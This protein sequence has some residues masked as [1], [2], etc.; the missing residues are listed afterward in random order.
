MNSRSKSC[1]ERE[2]QVGRQL[3]SHFNFYYS[4]DNRKV[5]GRQKTKQKTPEKQF[6]RK[7][8]SSTWL[9]QKGQMQNLI[10]QLISSTDQIQRHGLFLQP[11][12]LH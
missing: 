9:Q 4:L 6:S 12:G 2:A 10:P 1:N 8:T 5:G 3:R 7:A 11:K